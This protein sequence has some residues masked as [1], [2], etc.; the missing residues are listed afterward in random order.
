MEKRATANKNK[1]KDNPMCLQAQGVD[2]GTKHTPLHVGDRAAGQQ[3]YEVEAILQRAREYGIVHFEIK[4]LGW[5]A[6]SNTWEPAPNLVGCGGEIRGFEGA[7]NAQ[8]HWHAAQGRAE[9]KLVEIESQRKAK[10]SARQRRIAGGLAPLDS[11]GD[12]QAGLDLPNTSNTLTS[13]LKEELMRGI[14]RCRIKGHKNCKDP[15]KIA[16]PTPPMVNH[17]EWH[18]I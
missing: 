14:A 15:L 1:N 8:L 3:Q 6:V 2:G 12:H 17:L 5:A 9:T 18:I 13:V 11:D 4:W 16:G 7:L 10:G